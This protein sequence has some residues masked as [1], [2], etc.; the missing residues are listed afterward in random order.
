SC[1]EYG[2]SCW[3]AHGKR[4]AGQEIT[5]H[6]GQRDSEPRNLHGNQLNLLGEDNVNEIFSNKFDIDEVP[7]S[8]ES[9]SHNALSAEDFSADSNDSSKARNYMRLR[10]LKF[11]AHPSSGDSNFSPIDNSKRESIAADSREELQRHLQPPR[12]TQQQRKYPK[13]VERWRKL[14]IFGLRHAFGNSP[15]ALT[16]AVSLELPDRNAESE[17][18]QQFGPLAGGRRLDDIGVY[19]D[20]Q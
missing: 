12:Q 8:A 10:R 18:I 17:F 11:T 5:R 13:Y 15:L 20:F 19:Y 14:P 6:K 9:S 4:S 16:D 7:T 2:H 1:L 3:G